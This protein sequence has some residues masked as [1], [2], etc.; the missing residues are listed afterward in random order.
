MDIRQY[1]GFLTGRELGSFSELIETYYGRRAASERIRQ[2]S[3]AMTKTVKNAADRLRRKLNLQRQEYEAT[4]DREHLRQCGDIIAANYH[5]IKRGMAVLKTENFYDPDGGEIEIKLDPAKSPQ[6]NAARY[7]K[8]YSKAKNAEK[9]LAEQIAHGEKELEYL[10]SVL[11]EIERA[12]GER[13]L[14]EIRLEL[15]ESGYIKGQTKGK[16]QQKNPPSGKPMEYRSSSGFRI[17]VGRNNRENDALTLKDAFKTDMWLHTQKIHGSHV[18]ISSEGRKIDDGTIMEAAMLA[19]LYSQGKNGA[20]VPVDYTLVKY[21]KK[22]A[23]ARPG[24][25]I[26]TDYKTAYVT[27]DEKL[28]ERLRVK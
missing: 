3:A 1:E 4:F 25:V 23:G 24:M 9:Y 20:N 6:Q 22:P 12:S 13:D 7:Y 5:K 19:A 17:R 11:E 2:R 26:Y 8:D 14:G 28:A 15:Q 21:V 16:K 18:I 10:E 27:P